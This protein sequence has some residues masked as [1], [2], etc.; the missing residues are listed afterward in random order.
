MTYL[1]RH[2]PARATRRAFDRLLED[3]LPSTPDAD[4]PAAMWMPRLDLTE[5]PG[6]FVARMDLP[7]I[8]PEDLRVDLQGHRLTVR[9]ERTAETREQAED[10]VRMERAFGTFFRALALP[11]HVLADAIEAT[12]EDGV[13]TL[14]IPKAE[15]RTPRRIEV[16]PARTLP[17]N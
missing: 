5:T 1:T 6:A 10:V 12:F 3:L 2:E 14:R 7:G 17:L 9:G 11:E 4:E 16:Q 13:L 8:K 15:A